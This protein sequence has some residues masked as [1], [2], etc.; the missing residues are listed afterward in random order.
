M[1]D[2]AVEGI[3]IAVV[4]L[5]VEQIGA[6]CHQFA[7]AARRA[8]EAA[9]QL[10]PPR[11]GGEVQIAGGVT[12]R[13]RVPRLDRLPQPLFVRAVIAR[14]RTEK[15][16]AAGYVEM[17]ITVE[18]LAGDRGA[19]CFAGAGQQLLAQLDQVGGVLLR[20]RRTGPAQQDAA[21]LR[22]RAEQAGEEIVAHVNNPECGNPDSDAA[23]ISYRNAYCASISTVKKSLRFS[24]RP[25]R[26]GKSGWGPGMLASLLKTGSCEGMH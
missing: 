16:G 6:Q 20:I 5:D 11:L 24:F 10:L 18:H 1:H 8:V 17:L 26:A 23:N 25:G 4:V 15:R 3:E 13:L 21:A 22:N 2:V 14:Q 9:E 7:G 12:G 19:G